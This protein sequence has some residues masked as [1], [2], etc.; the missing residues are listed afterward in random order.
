MN[1]IEATSYQRPVEILQNLIRFNTTNPPGNE[2]A[3]IQYIAELLRAVGLEPE[4]YTLEEPRQNLV[5]RLAGRGE[6]P[7]LMLYGHVDVVTTAGQAW[8]YDPFSGIVEDGHIWGRGAL[9]MK[10]ELTMF[11][12]ALMRMKA[13]GFAPAGDVLFVALSDEENGGIFGAKYLIEMHADLFDGVRFALGEM[14]AFSQYL[15]G[16]RFYPIQVSEKQLCTMELT[17][18]GASGHGASII[19]GNAMEE[20]GKVLE[21]ISSK[22]LPVH[23]TP[24]VRETFIKI[25]ESLPFPLG[26]VI[27]LLLVPA[28]TDL[29]LGMLGAE[30]LLFAPLFH[31]TVNP[32]IVSGGEKDNVVPEEVKMQLDGRLL[33]GFTASDMVRELGNMLA[34]LDVEIEVLR[35]E[36]CPPEVD[37]GLFWL[38]EK[39]M[40]EMDPAG[41]PIPLLL[42]AVTDARFFSRLGIQSYGFTP[43]RLERGTSYLAGVHGVDE[44]LP[45]EA[46]TFGSEAVFRVLRQYK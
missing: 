25:S 14:G 5:C 21:I 26:L 6:A 31:N 15:A 20:L 45:V 3:C 42:T 23:I 12:V 24:V 22:R 40:K 8:Q 38:L 35:F 33:P 34:G 29:L 41:V 1:R 18:R 30:G 27:R 2:A 19:P 43:M 11:L 28:L 36:E 7:P 17:I 4:I 46:L 13:E 44:R 37:M 39:V 9:D 32:T 16:K 10:G